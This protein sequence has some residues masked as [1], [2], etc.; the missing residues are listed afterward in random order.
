VGGYGLKNQKL[1]VVAS[2]VLALPF[3]SVQATGMLRISVVEGSRQRRLVVEG[4]LFAP[5]AAELRSSWRR[6]KADLNGRELVVDLKGVTAINEDGERVL[7]ELMKQGARF[8]ASG[9]FTKQV[10]KWLA[11]NVRRN[12]QEEKK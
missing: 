11:A 12:V 10:L 1:S 9:V 8:R 6:A 5:W 4:K 7:L 3:P 2:L